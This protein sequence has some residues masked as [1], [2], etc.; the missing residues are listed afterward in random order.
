MIGSLADTNGSH[1]IHR[2]VGTQMANNT[3][4]LNRAHK[5]DAAAAAERLAVLST[6]LGFAATQA[7]LSCG[8]DYAENRHRDGAKG[9]CINCGESIFD[10]DELAE[11]VG[12]FTKSH[13]VV[14]VECI[15]PTDELA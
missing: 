8:V 13:K 10:T 14:H 5:Q 12:R 9:V 3:F 1:T 6:V 11:V 15:K 7:R 2:K 4:A